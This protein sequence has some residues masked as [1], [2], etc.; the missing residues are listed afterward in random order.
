MSEQIYEFKIG[1]FTCLSVNEGSRPFNEF[2]HAQSIY[3]DVPELAL[4]QAFDALPTAGRV[5]CYNPLYIQTP[6]YRVLIDTGHGKGSEQHGHL[7]DALATANIS[8]DMIDVVFITHYHGD[9][10]Y[11]LVKPDGSL[12]FSNARYMMSKKEWDSWM[13]SDP[14]AAL[15]RDPDYAARTRGIFQQIEDKLFPIDVSEHIVPGVFP[16]EAY[17]HTIGHMAILVESKERRLLHIADAAHTLLQVAHPEWSPFF[18]TDKAMA[19]ETR[20][21]LFEHAAS[22]GLLVHAFHFPFPALGY[23]KHQGDGFAWQP[24]S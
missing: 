3:P 4:R 13:G 20:R 9:H 19:A 14:V 16:V 23:I 24:L 22:D 5:F 21:R 2:E 15:S 10:I 11:G 6:E 7:L 8:P 18:D 12:V 1:E 17:G